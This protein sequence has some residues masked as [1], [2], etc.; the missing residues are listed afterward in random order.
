MRLIPKWTEKDMDNQCRAGKIGTLTI[1]LLYVPFFIPMFNFL[2][3]CWPGPSQPNSKGNL[4]SEEGGGE[5]GTCE[6]D[7]NEKGEEVALIVYH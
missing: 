1:I 4:L 2:V 6:K 5:K 3:K 7:V